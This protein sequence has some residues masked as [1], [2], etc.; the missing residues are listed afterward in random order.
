MA[1]STS[2]KS[3][4]NKLTRGIARVKG[5]SFYRNAK[6]AA[7]V[8]ML[9]GGK[10]IRDRTGKIIQAAAFQK[11]EEFA[12]PGRVQPDRRWFGNTRVISQD[13][14]SHFRNAMSERKEDPYS[15]L[16]RRNKLPMSL[17]DDSH[18]GQKR[19]HI[20]ETEPFEETF[21]PKAQRKRARIDIGSF[22]ELSVASIVAGDAH[23]QQEDEKAAAELKLQETSVADDGGHLGAS[24]LN[25]PEPGPRKP[26]GWTAHGATSA[27]SRA[28]N[29]M[30]EPVFSKGTSKRIYGELYKVIDSSDVII[31]VLDARD[32]LGTLCQSVIDY[33]KKEK[34]HKQV[35]YLINKVDLVPGW[36][37]QRHISHLTPTAPTLAFHASRNHS[38]GKGALIQLLRQ[39]AQLHSDRKQISVGFVGYPNVGKSSIINVLKDG[40][41]C[42][43]A[44]I[45]GQTKV[46]QYI[47]LT[48]RIYLI[49]CPGIV[50]ASAN[51]SQTSKVLKGVVRV[52]NLIQPSEHIAALLNRVRPIYLE[53]TYGIQGLLD[54]SLKITAQKED[55]PRDTLT[56]GKWNSDAFLDAVARKYGRLLKGGEPDRETVAKMVLNDW[57]RG[58]IPYFVR[59]PD[60]QNYLKKQ[61]VDPAQGMSTS[62]V[63]AQARS[64]QNGEMQGAEGAKGGVEGE[65]WGGVGEDDE[66]ADFDDGEEDGSEGS[67]GEGKKKPERE[68]R[69]LGVTQDMRGIITRPKFVKDDRF[70]AVEED[71]GSFVEGDQSS[72]G[73][74][75]AEEEEDVPGEEAEEDQV[76]WDDIIDAIG[77]TTSIASGPT[78]TDIPESGK[79]KGKQKALET[80]EEED[81]EEGHGKYAKAVKEPRMKTNKKK[82]ANFFTHTNVKNR[83]R[84]KKAALP[85]PAAISERGRHGNRKAGG[86]G[87]KKR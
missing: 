21:G 44:P 74:S 5:E 84:E 82:P 33:V 53:R 25:G 38:F 9:T 64:G 35:V 7:R 3:P 61:E 17:L 56:A 13:A 26:A 30:P 63:T 42:S 51:D 32:P 15:V 8:K 60:S 14:L 19:P 85:N 76:K 18:V 87:G 34:S 22:E 71:V 47:T 1:P 67:D 78:K 20:V 57:I 50:P 36:V 11:G 59:P 27:I 29:S 75:D 62:S 77:Q 65:E 40:K 58:K 28:Y 45:P 16:L 70:G 81:D 39:F 43:V 79:S 83:N 23:D 49:D 73:A 80:D 41:V 24:Y 46:W 55:A 69:T 66:E 86:K 52:E 72:E 54:E 4:S 37:T 31:H 12:K 6:Q 10:P 68:P 2:S 48:R